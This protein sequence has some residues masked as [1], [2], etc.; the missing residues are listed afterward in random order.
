MK[1]LGIDEAGRGPV[2]GPLIIAGV[3]I[4][5][6]EEGKLGDVRDSKLVKHDERLKLA[7]K[8]KENSSFEIIEVLPEEI[9]ETLEKKGT[10]LNWLE[11]E[12]QAEIINNLKPKKAI[13]DCPSPNC[14]AYEEKLRGMLKDKKVILVVEHK[15]DMNYK[16]C[17]AASILAKVKREEEMDKIK[18]KYGETGPGYASNSVTQKFV[19]ENWEKYPEI[20]RKSWSTFQ[21]HKKNKGQKKLF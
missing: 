8:I 20:F 7:K 19:A 1:T 9:D 12:K 17:A 6:V 18:E 10:N 16:T 3:M 14:S 2:I 11:A 5:E 15:A 21:N 4:E 13:I